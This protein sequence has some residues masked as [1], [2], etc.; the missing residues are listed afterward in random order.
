MEVFHTIIRE[1]PVLLGCVVFT[2]GSNLAPYLAS[3]VQMST[4]YKY[5]I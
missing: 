2:P 3:V 1:P 5:T 4:L